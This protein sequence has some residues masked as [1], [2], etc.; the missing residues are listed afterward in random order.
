MHCGFRLSPPA[1]PPSNQAENMTAFL[2]HFHPSFLLALSASSIF[3]CSRTAD[4][5]G[6]PD[7]SPDVAHRSSALVINGGF[8]AGDLSGWTLQTYTNFGIGVFPPRS[9][10]DLS[11][12][13]GGNPLTF[14][15]NGP[16]GTQ[17]PAG[18][19]SS[20]TMRYPK[21]GNWS[22]VINELGSGRNVNLLWQSFQT[23]SADVDPSDGNIHIRFTIAP[24]LQNP[25]HANASQPYFYV[26]AT[27]VTKNQVMYANFNFANE[28]GVPWQADVNGVLYTDWQIVD[29]APGTAGL[30]IGDTVRVDVYGA[31]C[32]LGGHFGHVYVDAFGASLPGLGISGSGPQSANA[33]SNITYTYSV[34]NGGTAASTNVSLNS[35]LPANTTFFSMS[36]PGSVTCTT[37]PVGSSGTVSCNLGTVNPSANVLL[38]LTVNITAGT[39]GT[40]NHGNYTIRGTG[41]APLIG[42]LIVTN[43]TSGVTYADLSIT[44]TDGVAAITWGQLNQYTIV[45]SNA[46][47]NN[48]A[49]AT[50]ADTIPAQLTSAS[51]TCTPGVGANCGGAS[52]VGNIG[53]TVDLNSGASATFQLNV[54]VIAGSGTSSVT[55]TAS[56]SPPAG[57]T[58]PDN[59]NNT[60]ADL[61][62]IGTLDT[63]TVTKGVTWPG[64][65]ISSPTAINCPPGCG[66]ASG[67]FLDGSMVSLSA[68]AA[69][70]AAFMGWTGGCSGG[71]S[72]CNVTLTG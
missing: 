47:P 66:S 27:N 41:E 28:L 38:S 17:V 72:P 51:W 23:T 12:R 71:V 43:V 29:V 16:T 30:A 19:T 59:R 6:M 64:T 35:V 3:G 13:T 25:G 37:P 4:V 9:V 8:E 69:T 61:D 24:V 49:G 40:I 67:I 20:S 14:A 15:R 21:Y 55:N 34:T 11:L 22:G 7:P 31:G 48:V 53:T 18:L 54:R 42:P 57:V 10:A 62:A 68:I 39:T 52:G 56:I 36:V 26:V 58:D 32:A 44:K 46:G 5:A 1:I 60:A 33:G 65:L 70:G 63:L 2:R 50:V 45:V